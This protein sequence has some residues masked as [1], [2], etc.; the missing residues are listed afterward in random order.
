MVL[1][2]SFT[3]I[4]G[5]LIASSTL[6]LVMYRTLLASLVMGLLFYQKKLSVPNS[7]QLKKMLLVGAILGIH[8]LCFFGSARMSTVSISLITFSTTSFFT[9]LLEP[10]FNKTKVKWTNVAL[11]TLA[12]LGMG[13]IFSFEIKHYQAIL[14]G[15]AG[16]LLAALYTVLN[17]RMIKKSDA[18]SI[19]L[20]VLLGAF[21]V[22]LLVNV[23]S[24]SVA[25]T[26]QL[27]IATDWL[28]LLILSIGCTVYPYIE[29]TE[30]LKRF[31][32][33]TINMAINMEPVYGIVLA[34][35]FFG[36]K[37][38]M[39]AGFYAGAALI[40]LSIGLEAYLQSKEKARLV[41]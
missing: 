4:L 20:F 3:A 6:S 25:G 28:W 21:L 39:S 23:F 9:S 18:V 11:G 7:I 8:W 30:L 26:A 33:F 22:M 14:I 38:R 17:G 24:W 31:S 34:W 32:A 35:L 5:K 15:L 2:L 1:I 27:P 10:L 37:E 19:N 12:I 36:E 40:M 16:A 41:N 29:M 13:I